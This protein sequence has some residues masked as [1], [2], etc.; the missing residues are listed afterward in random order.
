MER[1]DEKRD[2]KIMHLWR[3]LIF[4]GCFLKALIIQVCIQVSCRLPVLGKLF[5]LF[6]ERKCQMKNTTLTLNAYW[7]FDIAKISWAGTRHFAMMF[8]YDFFKKVQIGGSAVD[9]DL[10]YL[11]GSSCRLFDFC[12]KGRPLVINFGSLS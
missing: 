5:M 1:I 3:N 4:C 6:W 9:V 2:G 12:K 10:M 11:D 7:V 8:Y